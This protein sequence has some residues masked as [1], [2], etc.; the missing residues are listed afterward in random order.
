M[1]NFPPNA[2]QLIREDLRTV[3]QHENLL[4]NR[5]YSVPTSRNLSI[6]I[7]AGH[8][9]RRTI[10]GNTDLLTADRVAVPMNRLNHEIH[11][12]LGALAGQSDVVHPNAPRQSIKLSYLRNLAM[13][14]DQDKIRE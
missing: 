13:Q 14:R 5:R 1:I 11:S 4:S 10:W 7:S 3:R 9:L 6:E 12:I 8:V 2:A